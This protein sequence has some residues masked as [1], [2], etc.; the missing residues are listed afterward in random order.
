M[1]VEDANDHHAVEEV[2]AREGKTWEQMMHS[3]PDALHRRVQR[4][5]PPPNILVPQLW[6]LIFS[7]QNVKCSLD[8]SR[9][10]LFSTTAHKAA[11]GLL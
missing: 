11:E 1:L 8:P 3:N 7:W 9:G 10:V 2:L 4:L 6:A 5:C